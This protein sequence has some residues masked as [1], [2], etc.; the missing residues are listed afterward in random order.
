MAKRS[1]GQKSVSVSYSLVY[2]KCRAAIRWGHKNLSSFTAL[3][4]WEQATMMAFS[5][6]EN[7]LEVLLSGDIPNMDMEVVYP[8]R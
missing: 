1:S 3:P 6:I 5:R 8:E 2:E 4:P 7:D